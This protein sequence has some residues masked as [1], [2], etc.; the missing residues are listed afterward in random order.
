MDNALR[1]KRKKLAIIAGE[2][3][4]Q[5]NDLRDAFL[6]AVNNPVIQRN[7]NKMYADIFVPMERGGVHRGLNPF[8]YAQGTR[9]S[10]QVIEKVISET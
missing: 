5:V 2:K 7:R 8:G 6:R 4:L 1:L 9:A 10:V 3:R